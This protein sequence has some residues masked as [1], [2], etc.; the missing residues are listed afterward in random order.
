M[1]ASVTEITSDDCEQPGTW[2]TDPTGGDDAS[3]GLWEHGDPIGTQEQAGVYVQPEDDHT[4]T[5][6]VNCW[7]TGQHAQGQSTGYNDVDGGRTTLET[8]GIDV[9]GLGTINVSYWRWYSNDQGNAPG[10]DTWLVQV[11]GD[12]GSDWST[13]ESTTASSSSWVQRSFTL[14]DHVADPSTLKLRFVASDEGSGSLVEAAVDDLVIEASTAV[15]D[16]AAPTVAVT[17][18][19]G[20][21][22]GNGDV[23][24]IAWDADDDVGVVHARVWLSL[25]DGQTYDQL[26][27][28]GPLD[29][30]ASWTVDV[31]ADQSSYDARVRVEVLDGQ[32]RLTAAESPSFTLEFN[33]TAADAPAAVL[34]LAQNHPNPFNPQTVITFSLP[35]AQRASLRIYDLQGKLV[36][37]LVVGE[38]AAGVH[39][40]TWRGRDDRGGQ[41]ASGLYFYRL[42]SQ[43]G[44]EVRKMTLLK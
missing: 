12:G 1:V 35:R 36:R 44:D 43:D 11:S 18:P 37:T 39:E 16:V 31:P 42:R 28:E 21:I 6:G 10:Q 34:A 7:F 33:T 2:Q 26:L 3:S 41:V 9:T 27:A 29:G 25:D 24:D 15:A 38:I 5:P 4:P 32:E 40:V 14:N 19:S 17:R 30:A 22:F 8:P 20:G 23:L 13:V